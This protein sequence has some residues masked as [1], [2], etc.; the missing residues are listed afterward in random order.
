VT[1]KHVTGAS[2]TKLQRPSQS[3]FEDLPKKGLLMSKDNKQPSEVPEDTEGNSATLNST[4]QPSVERSWLS[5]QE[6]IEY[7]GIG[8]TRF[9]SLLSSGEIPSAKLG[10]TRHIRRRD[11][12]RFL[13]AHLQ[14]ADGK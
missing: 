4:Q 14:P 10:R 2:V 5:P 11:L 12:D 6:A 1:Q 3:Q 8:R 9:Y 7:S 13:E